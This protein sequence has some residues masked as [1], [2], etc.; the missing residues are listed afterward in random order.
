M[1]DLVPKDKLNKKLTLAIGVFVIILLAGAAYFFFGSSGKTGTSQN[2]P[3]GGSSANTE[4]GYSSAM[5]ESE[6]RNEAL[7]GEGDKKAF[8][9]QTLEIV[10]IGMNAVIVR[11]GQ[12]TKIL[13]SGKE[14][15]FGDMSVRVLSVSYSKDAQYRRAIIRMSG[16]G[17]TNIGNI[18]INQGKEFTLGQGESLK[19]ENMDITVISIVQ[20]E[21][22]VKVGPETMSISNGEWEKFSGFRV[23]IKSIFYTGDPTESKAVLVVTDNK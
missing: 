15:S 14:Y 5:R 7:L 17:N 12:E 13:A 20:D 6:Q 11:I 1:A 8:G 21:V 23:E 18:S 4:A 2:Y 19:D 22:S 9:N 10:K 3:S 16:S